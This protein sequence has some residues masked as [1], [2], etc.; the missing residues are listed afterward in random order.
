[1]YQ[2]FKHAFRFHCPYVPNHNSGVFVS[3]VY[4]NVPTPRIDKSSEYWQQPRSELTDVSAC[5]LGRQGGD[6]EI[7]DGITTT[8]ADAH[9][10]SYTMAMAAGMRPGGGSREGDGACIHSSAG[11]WKG[12]D[13]RGK[14]EGRGGGTGER[15]RGRGRGKPGIRRQGQVPRR[16]RRV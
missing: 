9:A 12:E 15:E 5:D 7:G 14:A 4:F 16:V 8:R 13:G 2:R 1:M 10:C 6:R 11:R 3:V